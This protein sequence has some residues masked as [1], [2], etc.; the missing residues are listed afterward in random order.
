[1]ALLFTFSKEG[2]EH[3]EK[4]IRELAV[5]IHDLQ[6]ALWSCEARVQA[7]M[8]YTWIRTL[9]TLL[10]DLELTSRECFPLDLAILRGKVHLAGHRDSR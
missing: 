8:V 5:E 4:V 3:G 10:G 9:H 2:V 7:R 1:M 6:R